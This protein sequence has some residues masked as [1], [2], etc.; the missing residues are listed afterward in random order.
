MIRAIQ[1]DAGWIMFQFMSWKIPLSSI[2]G[3]PGR[4]RL[5]PFPCGRAPA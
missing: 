5:G 3:S 2:S 4:A 1:G